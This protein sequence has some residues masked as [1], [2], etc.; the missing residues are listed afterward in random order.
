MVIQMPSLPKPHYCTNYPHAI[1]LFGLAIHLTTLAQAQITPPPQTH[2]W[3]ATSGPEPRR[4]KAGIR[5]SWRYLARA[6]KGGRARP[7]TFHL[8]YDAYLF[9]RQ[10][11]VGLPSPVNAMVNGIFL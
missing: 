11:A 6:S 8:E 2:Y 3:R 10:T 1:S 5:L 4:P 9:S 7:L